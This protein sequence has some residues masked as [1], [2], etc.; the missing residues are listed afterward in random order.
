MPAML[1]IAARHQAAGDR[2]SASTP[3]TL[4]APG[5]A[6]ASGRA[7][8]AA[9]TAGYGHG[10][11]GLRIHPDGH[12][13]RLSRQSGIQLLFWRRESPQPS[14]D[15]NLEGARS[16]GRSLREGGATRGSRPRPW[17]ASLRSTIRIKDYLLSEGTGRTAGSDRLCTG[18]ALDY[19]GQGCVAA[20]AAR[21]ED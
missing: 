9:V 2:H 15:L 12:G 10:A 11:D 20:G 19:P 4:A 14:G 7:F 6:A 13:A 5:T 17:I 21:K 3:A 8:L 18:R 16:G 1:R